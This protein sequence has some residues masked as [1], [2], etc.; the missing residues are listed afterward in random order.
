MKNVGIRTRLFAGFGVLIAIFVVLSVFAA[1]NMDVLAD[2]T[3]NLHDHPM[4][5][6]TAIL[7]VDRD[8]LAMSRAMK[9]IAL[10]TTPAEVQQNIEL[11]DRA[12]KGVYTN[13]AI[14]KT[15]FLGDP[16]MVDA[17]MQPIAAWR[18][19]R[20]RVIDAKLDGDSARAAD[21]TRTDGAAQVEE[22]GRAI[23]T[24]RN[25]EAANGRA[26]YLS[27]KRTRTH[28]MTTFVI[29]NIAA[30]AFAWV[31]VFGLASS[32]IRPLKSA[33][34]IA[35]AVASGDLTHRIEVDR[36]DETGQL[37]HALNH[38]NM[39]LQRM[40][41]E[42]VQS[43]KLASLGSMVAGI[44]HELN[45]PLGVAVTVLS[46]VASR[47]TQLQTSFADGTL[48]RSM[49]QAGLNELDESVRILQR[50]IT[51]AAGLVTS[52]KQISVDQTSERARQFDVRQT[53][54]DLIVTLAPSWKNRPVQ[55][56]NDIAPGIVC[57][58]LPGYIGQIVGNLLQNA[59][60]HAF[61][62]RSEGR[63]VLDCTRDD[64]GLKLTVTDDGT[65]I[66]PDTLNRI[67]EP[68]YTTKLGKGGSGLGL[69]IAH[70]IATTI[71]GGSLKAES[72]PGRG[73]RFTLTIPA[74]VSN[75][76]PP[77]AEQTS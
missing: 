42:L 17:I 22:I 3:K 21:I 6:T 55:V 26:L 44:S 47:V 50:S 64:Q 66:E 31:I 16:A 68:F 46:V 15:G 76:A 36:H 72:T 77:L 41:S 28:L 23:A 11:V 27:S 29:A 63:V 12:E 38:M 62:D 56:S 43:E 20:D 65:G 59:M 71:L 70:R 67:F 45:T 61:D 13:M 40:Q 48:K 39:S 52:F 37:L 32:I 1:R 60:L 19:I 25:Q 2:N 5:V 58:S 54:D 35:N 69:S 30:I 10:A 18:P 74:R 51:R 33:I 75:V 34:A 49:L 73:T 4:A 57:H 7:F 8:I 53:I 14:V 24:L 9:D